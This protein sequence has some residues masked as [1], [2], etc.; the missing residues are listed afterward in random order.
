MAPATS[1]EKTPAPP[2]TPVEVEDPT[3]A[4]F[5]TRKIVSAVSR[6][7]SQYTRE[8]LF[9]LLNYTRNWIQY[10]VVGFAVGCI[11]IG[12]AERLFGR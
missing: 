5:W 12:A 6:F 11:L 8:D 10:G 3:R 1:A 2:V 9:A 7:A 4:A